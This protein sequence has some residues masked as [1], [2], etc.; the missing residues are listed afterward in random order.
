M[1]NGTLRWLDRM[2]DY[3]N[4]ILPGI[5]VHK[6]LERKLFHIYSHADR[7]D[8]CISLSLGYIMQY[9]YIRTAVN[10]IFHTIQVG[11][12]IR[13][14]YQQIHL[15]NDNNQLQ[16]H[17]MRY[18][19]IDTLAGNSVQRNHEGSLQHIQYHLYQ[20]GIGIFQFWDH[21]CD[22]HSCILLYSLCQTFLLGKLLRRSVL[23]NPVGIHIVQF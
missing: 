1:D 21:I 9:P 20:V 19:Y 11:I 8:S 12:R 17:K 3:H 13:K 6:N 7:L 14:V 15:G 4:Y 5:H 23:S 16:D 18:V 10:K 22:F 2:N